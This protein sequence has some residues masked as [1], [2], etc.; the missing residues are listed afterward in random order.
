MPRQETS[1]GS[2]VP[3]SVL[4]PAYNAGRFLLPAIQSILGQ[5]Y[6]HFELLVIDDGSNDGSTE[7]LSGIT[8]PRLRV[9]RHANNRGIAAS[10]QEAVELARGRYLAWAD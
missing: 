9:V 8:D 7:Q 2:E 5:T 3:V 10:R 6:Q 1:M 4:M